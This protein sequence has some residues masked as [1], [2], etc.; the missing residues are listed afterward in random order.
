[1][2]YDGETTELIRWAG[3]KAR[4]MGH[5]YVDSTHLLLAMAQNRGYAG[6]VLRGFGFQA[7]VAED[8]TVI[9]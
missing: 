7:A 3:K 4:E 9:L 1:L 5:S 6:N 2:N 8:M